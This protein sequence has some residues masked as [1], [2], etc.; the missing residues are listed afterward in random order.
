MGSQPDV[1]FE[2]TC[3]NGHIVAPARAQVLAHGSSMAGDLGKTAALVDTIV[4]TASGH[5]GA[6]LAITSFTGANNFVLPAVIQPPPGSTVTDIDGNV[7]HTITI[8]TQVWMLEN[9]KATKYN[10]GTDIPAVVADTAPGYCWYNNN[11]ATYKTPYGA[12]YN[13]V[14]VHSGKLAPA[15]WHV[16]TDADWNVIQAYLGGSSVAGGAMKETGTTHWNGST[17]ATNSSGFTALPGGIRDEYGHFSSLGDNGGY[18]SADGT[19]H[20]YVYY[21]TAELGHTGDSWGCGFS[22]RCVRN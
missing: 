7:Y 8:G 3:M 9:F 6:R 2:L 14:S 5:I 13:W 22:V 1:V 17:G 11:A 19:Q 12:L 10:D 18:W 4:V 15:G 20:V 21:G 16:P